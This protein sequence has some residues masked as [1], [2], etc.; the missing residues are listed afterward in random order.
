MKLAHFFVAISLTSLSALASAALPQLSGNLPNLN[1]GALKDQVQKIKAT[2]HLPVQGLSIV[3]TTDGK[4]FLVSDNGRFAVIGGRWIDLFEGKTI[5]GIADSG[6]L[7]KLN[8]GRMGINVEEFFS[9]TIGDGEKVVTV[10]VDPACDECR[11]LV[12]Q[13][14]SL[15]RRFTF[16]VVILPLSGGP[17]G[18]AARRMS[19]SPDRALALQAFLTNSYST[20]P[21]DSPNCDVTPVQKAMVTAMVLGIRS[22][23]YFIFPDY[24]TA[25]VKGRG[26]KLSEIVAGQ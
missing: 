7:D 16:R 14:Q 13:M 25:S 10:F 5:T 15:G 1:N 6:T 26:L 4:T 8:L 18:S 17:S 3:E 12:S 19:C 2:K 11:S 24:V 21:A 23:P 20:L 22:T 9:Y